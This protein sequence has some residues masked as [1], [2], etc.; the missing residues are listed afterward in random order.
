MV[1][2]SNLSFS[3]E[4]PKYHVRKEKPAADCKRSQSVDGVSD[5]FKKIGPGQ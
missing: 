2:Q 4:I 1:G 3:R 5:Y